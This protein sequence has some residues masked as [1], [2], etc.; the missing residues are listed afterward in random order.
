[1]HT[2]YNHD[3]SRPM[4]KTNNLH[5]RKQRPRSASRVTAKLI[6]AFV[7]ATRI[8]HFLFF[9][10]P[11]FQASSLLLR[12]YSLICVGPVRKPHCWFSHEAAHMITSYGNQQVRSFIFILFSLFISFLVWDT[13]GCFHV[14]LFQ[15]CYRKSW[16]VVN[17]ILILIWA[18]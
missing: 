12:L 15:W 18:P 16:R 13:T 10:N 7:F 3:M 17:I 9:L 4:G 5:M 8:V 6:S 2:A 1:M 14:G 11:K